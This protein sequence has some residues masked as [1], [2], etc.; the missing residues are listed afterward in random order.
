MLVNMMPCGV[1]TCR[2]IPTFNEMTRTA[3]SLDAGFPAR[4]RKSDNGDMRIATAGSFGF[5]CALVT[6]TPQAFGQGGFDGPGWYQ[7]TSV[8]SGKALTMDANDQSTVTQIGPRN[9]EDQ[10]WSVEPGPGGYFYIRNGLN[11][12]TLEPTAGQNSAVVLAA[13][14]QGTQSQGWRMERGKDGNALIRNYY[15]KVLDLPD[16]T[17]RDG[18]RMQI[19]DANGDSN[20]RWVFQRMSGDYGRRWRGGNRGPGQ[21]MTC[22]S[23]DGRRRYCDTDTRGGVRLS[24]QI[25][26]SPC[27]QGET[28]GFDRRGVWVDRG[29]RA[30]FEVGRR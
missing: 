22:S 9:T 30:E 27:R 23:D 2:G 6:L 25:S 5:L 21:L 14:F 24:R 16:G 1:S 12:N 15:G 13:P 4:L 11:G 8:K 29:C 7:I 20:Q 28:W 19:Y 10:F 17:S 3:L 18:V 26:G